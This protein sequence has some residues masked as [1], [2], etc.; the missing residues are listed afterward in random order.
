MERKKEGKSPW[1]EVY[2]RL[3]NRPGGG[4]LSEPT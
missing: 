1:L 4:L 2:M 3:E